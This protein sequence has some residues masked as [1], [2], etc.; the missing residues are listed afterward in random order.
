MTVTKT[1]FMK[2]VLAFQFFWKEFFA[3]FYET[4]MV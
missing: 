2:L 1:K 4:R 3:E